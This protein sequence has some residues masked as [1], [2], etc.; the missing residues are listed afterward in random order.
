MKHEYVDLERLANGVRRAGGLRPIGRL[1][2]RNA[3]D[4]AIWTKIITHHLCCPRRL[5]LAFA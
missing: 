2:P 4:R 5:Q 1:L 3:V